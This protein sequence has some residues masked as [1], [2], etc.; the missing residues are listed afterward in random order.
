MKI[1]YIH[2]H[3]SLPEE[4]G[5]S[6]PYE[7]ARRMAQEGH[8]VTMLCGGSEA[9]DVEYEGIHVK[10]FAIEYRN[11]MSVP[12]RISSFIRFMSCASVAAAKMESDVIYASSTPLTIAVPGIAGKLFRRVP[13]IFE[14][15]DLWPSVPIELGYLNNR[16]AVWLARALEKVAYYNADSIVALSPGMRDG[17]L[18]IS[19][20]KEVAMIPNA[21]DFALF[22]RTAKQRADFRKFQGWRDDETIVVY[23][24][25]FGPVYEL[26]WVTRLAGAVKDD[27]IR[28]ILIGEGK[29]SDMVYRLAGEIGLDPGKMFLGLLPRE[30]VAD[31]FAA[32]D[33]VL[34]SVRQEPCLEDASINKI[35]DG[36][37]AGR[38]ILVNHGGWLKDAVVTA[39]A[40][41]KLDRSIETAAEQLREIARDKSLLG[42]AGRNSAELGRACFDRN[43]LYHSLMEVIEGSIIR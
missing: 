42:E 10:R 27:G 43:D 13:F 3:F 1:T 37:A 15:R 21:C 36:M 14:V 2:Q 25:G 6:R 8:D 4:G 29:D 26:D 32:G 18:K 40:G 16:L 30:K 9:L 31:Y 23:A 17:V 20:T 39:Q 34:S 7:F 22:S 24:G 28:F 11:S 19:P 41:W 12:A 35:F 38:P 5:G 33:I